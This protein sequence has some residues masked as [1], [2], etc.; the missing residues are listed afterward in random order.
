M[1]RWRFGRAEK[2]VVDADRQVER[3]ADRFPILN[4]YATVLVVILVDL[5]LIGLGGDLPVGQIFI[6]FTRVAVLLLAL[7]VSRV[8]ARLD[9]L[10]VMLAVIAVLVGT[11]LLLGGTKTGVTIATLIGVVLI[12]IPP[13]AIARRLVEII[14]EQG[15]VLEAVWAALSIY[16][17]IG[18]AYAS[19][20]SALQ[21][22]TGQPF[23]VQE[24]HPIAIDFVYFS[25]VTLTTTGYGDFT[26][27]SSFARMLAVSE[28]L[29]GQLYLVTVVA[30]IVSNL[31]RRQEDERILPHRPGRA[32]EPEPTTAADPE[33]E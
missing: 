33:T 4:T 5:L 7:H 1:A 19:I 12:L 15:V 20:F 8:R 28:G 16:L 13:F 27:A 31:R 30:T 25:F 29:F 14:R 23:F 32:R 22:I 18:L 3:W 2:E 24:A 21:Q 26:A 6:L 10:A 11:G 17:L 9:A